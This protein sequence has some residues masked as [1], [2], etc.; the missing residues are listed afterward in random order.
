MITQDNKT[1]PIN[2]KEF[3]DL[4]LL[5]GKTI[6]ELSSEKFPGLLVFPRDFNASEDLD[7]DT[8][9]Y[10]IEVKDNKHQLVTNNIVGFIGF[11]NTQLTI[12]SRFAEENEEDYFLHYMLQKVLSLNIIELKHK[13]ADEQI[14]DFLI[15]LFP[16][17]LK[18]AVRQGIFKEYQNRAYDNANIKGRIN[19][20]KFIQK[21]LPFAGHIAYNTREYCADNYMSQ[22]IRHT[23]EYI[24]DYSF[25]LRQTDKGKNGDGNNKPQQIGRNLLSVDEETKQAVSLIIAHTPSYQRRNRLLIINKNLKAV[26]H[27]YYSAYLPLQR[28]C[29]QILRHQGLKYG[30][31]NQK[32]QGVLFD[33]AWLWEEYL[34]T[35]L[36]PMGY[37]HPQ[38]KK[39][40]G[41]I[42]LFE[43]NKGKRYPDF[44]KDAIILD[45]K[46]KYDANR[47]DYHQMITY[48]YIRQGEKGIFLSP[49]STANSAFQSSSADNHTDE[50]YR[51][52]LGKLNGY[53]G[54]LQSIHLSIPT[55]CETYTDF[56]QRMKKQEELLQKNLAFQ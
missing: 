40:Q 14:L 36:K 2:A 29:L 32:I 22:L 33:A 47:E 54:E 35:L 28:L 11:E 49:E 17:L 37:E 52:H 55:H 31:A 13:T 46:Y 43:G 5:A 9:L 42:Y 10:S 48:L 53:G 56:C 19:V 34:H 27:P 3:E 24:K 20:S 50:L 26:R 16:S 18:R 12:R 1:R 51:K 8:L 21:D 25:G 4:Q 23:I 39:D 41:A 44:Y 45:A 7:K 38:N 6:G 30:Q 15:Y